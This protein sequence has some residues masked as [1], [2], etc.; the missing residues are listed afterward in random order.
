MMVSQIMEANSAI[1]YAANCA[2]KSI[3]RKVSDTQ[4]GSL[5]S[6]DHTAAPPVMFC[7]LSSAENVTKDPML[8]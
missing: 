3:H 6:P 7:T 8:W 4:K 5:I 2:T 1:K